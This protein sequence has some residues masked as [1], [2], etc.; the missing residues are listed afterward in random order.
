M[1]KK[2]DK[3]Y[4]SIL[5]AFESPDEQFDSFGDD[6]KND[7]DKNFKEPNPEAEGKGWSTWDKAKEEDTPLEGATE[8]VNL[9]VADAD[10]DD[11]LEN[12]WDAG[13]QKEEFE[14][15]QGIKAQRFE[16]SESFREQ[17]LKDINEI[18]SDTVDYEKVL[19]FNADREGTSSSDRA[20]DVSGTTDDDANQEVKVGQNQEPNKELGSRRVQ[21]KKAEGEGYVMDDTNYFQALEGDGEDIDA[22][23]QD[24][25]PIE[26]KREELGL[27]PD[28]TEEEDHGDHFDDTLDKHSA[29][30]IADVDN[31]KEFFDDLTHES[32]VTEDR[33][34]NMTAVGSD[35]Q[36]DGSPSEYGT[37]WRCPE[38][39]QTYGQTDDK[40]AVY[41]LYNVHG[42]SEAEAKNVGG[43]LSETIAVE[44]DL[45]IPEEKATNPTDNYSA[46]PEKFTSEKE[47]TEEEATNPEVDLGITVL[48]EEDQIDARLE[49]QNDL[50]TDEI[51][52]HD[53][54]QGFADDASG[55]EFH[56]KNQK[57]TKI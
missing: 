31:K 56:T 13:T 26:A 33:D 47:A 43:Y 25:N 3:A 1:S 54:E 23:E 2:T 19:D 41:H 37:Q 9:P 48:E 8:D 6:D 50:A 49:I 42:Y 35:F 46:E 36:E 17:D 53:P 24:E 14:E 20:D 16:E 45:G 52:G 44:D 11:D 39:S 22:K 18:F 15:E 27:E 51:G 30:D 12:E 38:C 28:A 21:L 7:M 34:P 29:D 5:K 32:K 4:E 10:N 40:A 55:Q 57:K